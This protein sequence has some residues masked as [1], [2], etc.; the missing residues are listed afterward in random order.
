MLLIIQSL[1]RTQTRE[2]IDRA[3]IIT[4]NDNI[5]FNLRKNH[6]SRVRV[7]LCELN[8]YLKHLS[9]LNIKHLLI[10]NYDH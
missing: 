7:S 3:H 4:L 10:N 6:L 5:I 1:Q 9:R 8:I 2:L